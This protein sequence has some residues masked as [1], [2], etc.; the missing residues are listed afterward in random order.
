MRRCQGAEPN[1]TRPA[2]RLFEVGFGQSRPVW[3]QRREAHRPRAVRRRFRGH[4]LARGHGSLRR[5]DDPVPHDAVGVFLGQ[6]QRS[7]S[8]LP[9]P[10]DVF[11]PHAD[12]KV[13]LDAPPGEGVNRTNLPVNRLELPEGRLHFGELLVTPYGRFRRPLRFGPMGPNRVS[14]VQAGL[15]LEDGFLARVGERS[16][17]DRDIEVRGHLV[18]GQEATGPQCHPV[19][20]PPRPPCPRRRRDQRVPFLL[21]LLEPRLPRVSLLVRLEGIPTPGQTF[22]GEVLTL[23]FSP[24]RLVKQRPRYI[25][26]L[27]NPAES[28]LPQGRDPVAS[29]RHRVARGNLTPGRSQHRT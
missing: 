28:R 9:G 24:V 15:R 6:Q 10:P 2:G 5:G 17:G 22:A 1:L 18:L 25:L 7:P 23:H 3:H 13:G 19:R 16:L 11:G 4:F 20:P 14:P 8:G 29:S 26:L 21:G 27:H 12:E